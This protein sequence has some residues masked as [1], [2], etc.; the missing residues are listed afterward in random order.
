MDKI[1]KEA[2]PKFTS[3]QSQ[4]LS[5]D[6][7]SISSS[8]P[9]NLPG[10]LSVLG[11]EGH[12]GESGEDDKKEPTREQMHAAVVYLLKEVDFNTATLSDILKQLGN[13]FGVDLIHRKAEVK[14][15]ITEVIKN[16]SDDDDESGDESGKDDEA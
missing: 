9:M 3:S 12:D 10:K 15:I 6:S 14:E 8:L 4:L 1:E 11:K 2:S 7:N 5:G 13:H 16:M